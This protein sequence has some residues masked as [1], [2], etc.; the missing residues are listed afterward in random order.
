MDTFRNTTLPLL[1]K[2]GIP[3]EGLELKI[4][5]RGAVRSRLARLVAA[6]S[7]LSPLS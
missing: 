3:K 4:I 7:P 2:A 6:V 1:I 5:K